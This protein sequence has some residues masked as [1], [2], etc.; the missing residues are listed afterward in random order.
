MSA[1]VSV[2]VTVSHCL[3]HTSTVALFNA[4]NRLAWTAQLL[5]PDGSLST[6]GG[7]P[8]SRSQRALSQVVGISWCLQHPP[9]S[10]T[11]AATAAASVSEAGLS[12]VPI[13]QR[14][15]Y[16]RL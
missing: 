8:L 9:T 5:P 15:R 4:K 16:M 1:L 13:K 10:S 6:P 7:A 14:I 2:L 11:S 3:T 12:L